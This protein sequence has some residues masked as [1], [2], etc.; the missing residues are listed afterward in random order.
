MND[1][2]QC[3]YVLPTA[4]AT[5]IFNRTATLHV[6]VK[7]IHQNDDLVYKRNVQVLYFDLHLL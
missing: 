5:S 1:T 6:Y 2:V 3:T 4:T 7:N